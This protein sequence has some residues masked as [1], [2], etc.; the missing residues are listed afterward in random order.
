LDAWVEHP[1][2]LITVAA[3]P[4]VPEAIAIAER[5]VGLIERRGTQAVVSPRKGMRSCSTA[6][7]LIRRAAVF[8]SATSDT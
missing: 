6:L 3:E 5:A 2:E 4:P 1:N 8:A 7:R